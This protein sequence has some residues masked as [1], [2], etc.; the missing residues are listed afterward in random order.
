MSIDNK[1]KSDQILIAYEKSS[2]DIYLRPPPPICFEPP[3]AGLNEPPPPRYPP[4]LDGRIVPLGLLNP[5]LGLD[6]VDGR[7]LGVP[8][9]LF[10]LLPPFICFERLP[11]FGGVTCPPP[12]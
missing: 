10:G 9:G 3:P 8:L 2:F 1:K 12:G 7:A 4:L 6:G 5:P 11:L